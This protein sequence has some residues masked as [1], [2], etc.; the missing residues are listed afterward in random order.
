MAYN[1]FLCGN[2]ISGGLRRSLSF[3]LSAVLVLSGVLVVPASLKAAEAPMKQ[4]YVDKATGKT[5]GWS[6]MGDPALSTNSFYGTNAKR[7]DAFYP[8]NGFMYLPEGA[9]VIPSYSITA[10]R[11]PATGEDHGIRTLRDVIDLTANNRIRINHCVVD[12]VVA[13]E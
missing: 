10:N 7:D 3:V 9:Q 13:L 6:V 12:D 11:C 2:R 5:S 8:N 4:H 1:H